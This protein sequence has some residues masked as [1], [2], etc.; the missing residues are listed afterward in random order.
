MRVTRRTFAV[1]LPGLLALAGCTSVKALE[2]PP[3]DLRTLYQTSLSTPRPVLTTAPPAPDAADDPLPALLQPPRVQ[4]VW[5]P[6]QRTSE[7]DLVVGH[8][9]YLLLDAPQWR[10]EP[11][12]TTSLPL[13]PLSLPTP[14]QSL[15]APA[16]ASPASTGSGSA[17]GVPLSGV[18]LPGSSGSPALS[19]LPRLPI[20]L[21]REVP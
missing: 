5:V 3:Q 10:L 1:I 13:A 9:T 21:S 2:G 18:T 12:P 8:W 20:P 19:T 6:T 16:Q 15:S 14:P 17:A 4:K 7:G 11:A